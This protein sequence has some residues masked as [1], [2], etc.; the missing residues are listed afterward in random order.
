MCIIIFCI[1][2]V[3][4]L[5]ENAILRE[6]LESITMDTVTT[7]FETKHS[8]FDEHICADLKAYICGDS[9]SENNESLSQDLPS[10]D[11][12]LA[13]I[14][15]YIIRE[16]L[17][18]RVISDTLEPLLTELVGDPKM[19]ADLVSYLCR[20]TIKS[21]VLNRFNK[22]LGSECTDLLSL[23]HKI[24]DNIADANKVFMSLRIC[25]PSACNGLFLCAMM[26]ELIAAKSQL[27]ILADK[28]GNPL[29]KYKIVVVDSRLAVLDKKEF[30]T[31]ELDGC[32]QEGRYL[33]EALY[34]EKVSIIRNCLFGV[35]FTPLSVL[36]CKL[37][38]WLDAISTVDGVKDVD[39]PY[40]EGNVICGEAL[41]SRFT[42]T[43]DL[44]VALKNINQTVVDYKRLAGSIKIVKDS[45][46]RQYLKEMDSL[47]KNRLV[48]GI[49]WYSKD[50]EELLK[51]RGE[52]S[53]LMAPGL[54]PLTEK[55]AQMRDER[56]LL[57][58][59]NIKNQ[60]NQLSSYRHHPVFEQ[61]VEWRYVFPE[62]LD[63]RG[64]FVGFDAV[65]GILP[66]ASIAGIGGD[67]A[68]LYKRMNYKIYKR[69]GNIS[70][71]YCEL[72][73]R[74]LLYGGCMSYIMPSGWHRD[75][76]NNKTGDY[77]VAE[78]NPSRLMLFDELSS[79]Y[80]MLKEK[81]AIVAYKDINR[82]HTVLCR[83]D[84]SYNPRIA[85]LGAYMQQYAIPVFRLVESSGDAPARETIS[86]IIASNAEYISI[87]N[88][89]KRKGILIKN[90]DVNIYTG[91]MTGC[92]EAFF[93]DKV[94]KDELIHA[95][96]KNSDIIKPL[97]TSDFIKQYG[98]GMPV[99]WLLYIPWHFPLQYDKTINVASSRAEQRFQMQYPD[100]YNRLMKY[101]DALSLRNTAEV[102]LGFEWYA[103]QR[104]GMNN[105]WDDFS[106]QKI[107]WKL[108]ASEF[109][110]GID[111]DGCAVLDDTCFM[112]GQHLKFLLGVFNST[113][114][115]YILTD[116]SRLSISESHADAF[117]VESMPV[118]VPSGKME[119]DVISLVNRRVSENNKSDEDQKM[120]EEKIDRLIFELYGLTEE[121]ILFVKAQSSY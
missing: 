18:I 20:E 81:C 16:D 93:V 48:E 118:P 117:I 1:I 56:I 44:I 95:D 12:V 61:A 74:L 13:K 100:V 3:K 68:S 67:K 40:L 112:V 107:V 73:N 106:E 86:S 88:K 6:M 21:I 99:Q 33:Q 96:Y 82:H 10:F 7:S 34:E 75:P 31:V 78:M 50:S 22:L 65:V 26:N 17:R 94:G 42:L 98:G 4:S 80:E 29:H 121:E 87:S 45:S 111:Y 36:I 105:N 115:R 92:D 104:S 37:R 116:L 43:D 120:T 55:E 63:E 66:D 72:A 70:D 24:G 23:S 27:G 102:G 91:V 90:W 51:L 64:C 19:P 46:D 77:L 119:S 25:D 28:K 103:L 2:F 38:L 41:V 59:A 47:I 57:L 32:T 110:F 84:A 89:V 62:L 5:Y 52:L 35:D 8:Y 83:I 114:G 14:N 49:G 76:S 54:F 79:E 11:E 9:L 108:D 58:H 30:K 71:L 53:S 101:K 85:D 97:L 69:T 39:L 109:N 113:M 15:S 60:E